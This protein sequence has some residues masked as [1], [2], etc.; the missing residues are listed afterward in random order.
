MKKAFTLAEILVVIFI[1]GLM[2]AMMVVNWRNNE[3]SYLVR[4]VAQELAQ[5]IRRAQDMALSGKVYNS[6]PYENYGINLSTAT[7][8]NYIVFGD[9]NKNKIYQSSSSDLAV[10]TVL[11]DSN[12]EIS[13]LAYVKTSAQTSTS[14]LNI[15]FSVP[16][17][18]VTINDSNQN[19]NADSAI[20]T[21]KKTGTTCPS[22]I[23]CKIITI[24][25][26]GQITIQ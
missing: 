16:D 3:K 5:D 12:V 6:N 25:N 2:S 23:N 21:I 17:G 1:I 24:T 4:R 8:Q 10:E 20:I 26:M 13:G 22:S 19:R 18:F 15:V 11:I 7:K 9:V 14:V